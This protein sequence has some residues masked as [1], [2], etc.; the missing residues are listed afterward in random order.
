LDVGGFGVHWVA[1]MGR[2]VNISRGGG[3]D[4]N[5]WW[6]GRLPEKSQGKLELEKRK[7]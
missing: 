5:R 6:S 7:G 1:A 2:V 4:T 3:T